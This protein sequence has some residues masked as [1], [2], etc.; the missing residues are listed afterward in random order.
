MFL[1]MAL[2]NGLKSVFAEHRDFT[3]KLT[4]KKTEMP[5]L[6]YLQ[7]FPQCVPE[8]ESSRELEE[9]TNSQHKNVGFLSVADS[10]AEA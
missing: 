8:V 4:F 3:V 10:G 6:R 1:I 7:R 2:N 5:S 9:R